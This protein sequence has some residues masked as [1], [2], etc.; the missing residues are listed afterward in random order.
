MCF[1]P[2]IILMQ[3]IYTIAALLRVAIIEKKAILH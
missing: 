3:S 2:I 1:Q